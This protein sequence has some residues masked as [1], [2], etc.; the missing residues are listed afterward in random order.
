MHTLT[1][2][3]KWALKGAVFFLL[4]AFALN[5][6]QETSIWLLFGQ[7]WRAPLNL[8]V[9]AA[10]AGGM[11]VGVLGMLPLWRRRQ[12]A[13]AAVVLQETRDGL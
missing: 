8:I 3:L 13:A 1:R 2:L 12:H 6:Q 5:N 10:F 7:Q 9:L 11:A 4:F